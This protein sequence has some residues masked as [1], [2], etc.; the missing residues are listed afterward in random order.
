MTFTAHTAREEQR[1]SGTFAYNQRRRYKHHQKCHSAQVLSTVR[2]RNLNWASSCIPDLSPL[3]FSPLSRVSVSTPISEWKTNL[4]YW[5]LTGRVSHFFP[6]SLSHYDS[7][8]IYFV[9]PMDPMD[10]M[11]AAGVECKSSLMTHLSRDQSNRLIY[12]LSS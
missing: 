6:V 12:A 4:L 3:L 8:V 2:M 11:N 9:A 5:T 10:P 1:V 7:T